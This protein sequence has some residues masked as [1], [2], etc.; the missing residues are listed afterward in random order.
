MLQILELPK[1]HQLWQKL[2]NY[3]ILIRD[4]EYIRVSMSSVIY[5]SIA[6]RNRQAIKTRM[7]QCSCK[8][9]TQRCRFS[10]MIKRT[11]KSLLGLEN[12]PNVWLKIT[13]QAT[14]VTIGD[15]KR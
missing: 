15:L 7:L 1:L 11:I 3:Q 12:L 13:S 2:K 6:E 14:L 10:L 5:F 9:V 4:L 8:E